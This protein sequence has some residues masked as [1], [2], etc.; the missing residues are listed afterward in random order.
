[1]TKETIRIGGASGYWGDSAMSTPQ[2]VADG[3]LDFIVYDYLAEV[4]MSIMARARANNPN[5]GFA[6]DFV[7]AVLAPNLAAIAQQGIRVISNAG[8]VNP[9]A[10]GK[11]V[12]ALVK[13]LG[14]NLNVAVITGDDLIDR[15]ESFTE[16]REMFRDDPFP[17]ISTIASINAYLGAFP[18]ADALSKG[19]DI[20][21]TGRVVD[22]AVTLGA[23]I[24]HFD[25]QA[26]DYDCLAGGSIAGHILECGAQ[27]TGGNFTDW[28][29]IADS[30]HNIG[31][32]IAEVSADGSFVCSKPK[33][34]GGVV[35]V[36]TIAEQLLYEVG[37][38]QSYILPDVI[39]DFS[40]L[41]IALID[42]D[43]VSITGAKGRP[44]TNT[45][46]VSATFAD[47]YRAGQTLL[48]YGD[49]ADRKATLFAEAAIKRATTR[50]QQLGLA[51]FD[52]TLIELI[53]DES[54]YGQSRAVT[55]SREVLL[56]VAVRHQ[57]K[58]A[59]GVFLQEVIG[60]AL[61]GPPSLTGFAGT[62]PR[63][64]PVVRLYSFAL[65]KHQ[66]SI[67]VH[68]N[69]ETHTARS[70][71]RGGNSV[72]ELPTPPP[73]HESDGPTVAVPLRQLAWGRSGD[74][75]NKANIGII[76]RRAEYL[77]FVWHTLTAELVQTKFAHF[78]EQAVDKF[79]VPGIHAINFLL[80]SVLGGGGI[81]S[82]RNDPQG[83]G[84]AQ[85]LLDTKIEVPV[86]IAEEL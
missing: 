45:Y 66:L 4:T 63:P 69:G 54:H 65:D 73:W 85:I 12:E 36:G 82:L 23:C 49:Q 84:Y 60:A 42:R 74:K 52:D 78:T 80:H 17:D 39:C 10:C 24:H 59:V 29:S 61:A 53:G 5:M 48:F 47:G 40:A 1:M 3:G 18:I 81:A 31:Y 38:P 51:P 77:P 8:G 33:G 86:S 76:A 67:T 30:M 79:Y 35:N 44:P 19:A 64:S 55:G 83:K 25:W 72:V 32:P 14:L 46:K 37:D 41:N 9:V 50:L 26:E 43:V 27:A 34:T 75:G 62:R 71:L 28:L 70:A 16:Q 7:T 58:N 6:P 57:E 15:A 22:S 68:M 21:I 56:K 13:K 11:A 20:V 2:L